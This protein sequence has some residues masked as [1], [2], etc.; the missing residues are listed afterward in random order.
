MICLEQTI[1][2]VLSSK[3]ASA[4]LWEA[5]VWLAKYFHIGYLIQI[6]RKY[7]V[8]TLT[9]KKFNFAFPIC[10]CIISAYVCE[11]VCVSIFNRNSF[12]H[13]LWSFW[14]RVFFYILK[15]F[16]RAFFEEERKPKPKIISKPFALAVNQTITQAMNQACFSVLISIWL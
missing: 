6:F 4:D 12:V 9:T 10:T 3:P 15:V 2:M 11:V 16:P 7:V 1:T 14:L 5:K 13:F 8:N